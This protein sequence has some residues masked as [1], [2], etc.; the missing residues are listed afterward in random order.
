MCK[1][2]TRTNLKFL[3]KRRRVEVAKEMTRIPLEQ[4]AHRTFVMTTNIE[5]GSKLFHSS[6]KRIDNVTKVVARYS[7]DVTTEMFLR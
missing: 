4:L 5:G 1:R 3:Q 2:R 7:E 6:T